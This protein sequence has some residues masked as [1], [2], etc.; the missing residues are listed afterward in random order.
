MLSGLE[1]G[2]T[3]VSGTYQVIRDLEDGDPVRIASSDTTR[4]TE[5]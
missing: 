4:V 1:E 2:A 5:E 3:V